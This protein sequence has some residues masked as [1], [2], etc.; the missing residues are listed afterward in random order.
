VS[1]CAATNYLFQIVTNSNL[2]GQWVTA[3]DPEPPTVNTMGWTGIRGLFGIT[4]ARQFT[5][6]NNDEQVTSLAATGETYFWVTSILN[7]N[8]QFGPYRGG[9]AF[10]SPVSCSVESSTDG[11]VTTVGATGVLMCH[12]STGAA[13][14]IG[15]CPGS[16]LSVSPT[17]SST[18]EPVTLAA[19][20]LGP[21]C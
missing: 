7:T 6:N 17:V 2:N 14:A 4:N 11:A 15:A 3:E 12:S 19:I 13:L 21:A 9:A 1:P 18:C 20:P 8:L 16:F 10:F 5:V